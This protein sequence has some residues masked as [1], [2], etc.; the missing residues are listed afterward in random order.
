VTSLL[1]VNNMNGSCQGSGHQGTQ[2]DPFCEVRDAVAAAKSG[3]R[4]Y[5]TVAAST[6]A[7]ASVTFPTN[8][9]QSGSIYITGASTDVGAVVIQASNTAA[10]LAVSAQ[11]GQQVTVGVRNIE[12]VGGNNTSGVSCSGGVDLTLV[13]TRVH[14]S[15]VDG[16]STTGC[17]LTVDASRIYSNG[18]RGMFI[19]GGKYS[20]TNIMVW[21]NGGGIAFADS[22]TGSLSFATIYGNGN[23]AT[24]SPSGIDCGSG[25][26]QVNYSIVYNN[27]MNGAGGVTTDVQLNGC[28]LTQVVTN[29]S[30]APAGAM[31]EQT[32]DFVSTTG[33]VDLHLRSDSTANHTCCIDK[34]S[35]VVGISNHDIDFHV[36]P[37][38]SAADI[39]AHEVQ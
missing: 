24:N 21:L 30:K 9:N 25:N 16:I 20:I 13:G 19:T 38:G 2:A 5:V 35:Q 34:V 27:I 29:D 14:G 33:N 18:G 17:A 12:L 1:F 7:Y 31:M 11:A 10:A 28:Q 39:G 32:V 15:S 4:T 37:A 23:I 6:Q 3:A 8:S 22:A 26:N 36:R